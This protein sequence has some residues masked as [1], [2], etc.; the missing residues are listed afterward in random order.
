MNEQT[1]NDNQTA[2]TP[3]AGGGDHKAMAVVAYILFFIPLLTDSKN[4]S[5]VRYHVRQGFVLFLA[6]VVV[7]IINSL[8]YISILGSILHI[9]IL[10]LMVLGIMNALNNKQQP[11]PI[12]GQFASKFNI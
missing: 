8:M 4:D 2:G 5:F 12:I 9:F 7:S 11:L 10:V 6:F 1:T 3:P